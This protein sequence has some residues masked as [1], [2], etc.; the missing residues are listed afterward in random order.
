MECCLEKNLSTYLDERL[1]GRL[2]V[3]CLNNASEDASKRIIESFVEQYADIFVLLDRNSR[4]YG[5]SINAAL[6]QARGRYFRI[7]DADDWVNTNELV[8]LVDTLEDCEVDIVLT[9]YQIVNMQNGEMTPVCAADHGI[10]YAEVAENFDGPCKT[11]PSIH[12][13]TYRTQLLRQC[14]FYMQDNMFF[15]DEEY[16][17]LPYLGANTVVY[18]PFDVYRYQVANPAQSTSP[19]NRAKYQ[20]H[21]EKVLCRLL[22]EYKKGSHTETSERTISYCQL[23]IQKGVGDH[24]TTLLIYVE[25]RKKGRELA[26]KWKAYLLQNFPDFWNKAKWKVFALKILNY[27]NISL[28]QYEMLKKWLL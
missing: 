12:N 22:E 13:T 9:D 24:F 23:R 11:L 27:M 21:R 10:T 26:N 25:D 18:Y 5:S 8:K 20:A 3:L 6:E 28:S 15:V 19:K 4:G 16:V 14:G 7:V 17:V 2:E 1:Q